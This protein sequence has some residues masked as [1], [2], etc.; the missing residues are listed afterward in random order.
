VAYN[1]LYQDL[2]PSSG[3]FEDS[4]SVTHTLKK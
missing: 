2:M 4:N 3:V 1:H